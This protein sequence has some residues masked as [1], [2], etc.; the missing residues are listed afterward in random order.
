MPT[1]ND[2]QQS[3]ATKRQS[4]QTADAAYYASLQQWSLTGNGQAGV[5]ANQTARN[6]A[7]TDLQTAIG[8]LQSDSTSQQ[9]ITEVA[10]DLPFLLLPVRVEA[11]YVT[12]R[13]MLKNLNPDDI[14][15]IS[16][17]TEIGPTLENTGF[18]NDEDG[19]ITYLV[20]SVGV[21]AA[22]DP[23]LFGQLGTGALAPRSGKWIQRKDDNTELRIRIYPDDIYFESLEQNLQSS[24]WDAGVAFW[25]SIWSGSDPQTQWLQL[26]VTYRPAR[27]AWIIQTTRPTNFVSGQPL[28]ASPVFP[29]SQ[30]QKDG[31]Y[32]EPPRARLLPDCFVVRLYKDGS[33]SEFTGA[34]IPEPLVLGLDPTD[35]PFN[36]D[37]ASGMS[38]GGTSIQTPD[39]LN[40]IHDFDA[41]LANGLALRVDLTENPQYQNGVDKILV[42][43]VKLSADETETET[44]L[45][46]LMQNH[47]YKED[48]MSIVT[49]GTATNNFGDQKSGYNDIKTEGLAYFNAQWNS[50]P[51]SGVVDDGTR[52]QEALGLGSLF[53][54][55]MGVTTEI[56]EALMMNELLWP[57][58]WGY[59]LL[60]YYSPAMTEATRELARQFFIQHVAARGMLPVVRVNRQPYGIIPTTSLAQWQYSGDTLTDSENFLSG[61]WTGFLSKLYTLWQSWIPGI[62]TV[63]VGGQG[64]DSNFI[65]IVSMTATSQQLQRQWMAGLGFQSLL[66]VAQP[67]PAANIALLGDPFFQPAAFTSAL[68]STGIAIA[69]YSALLNAY[70]TSLHDVNR[71]IMDG[72]PV[73][74]DRPLELIAAKAWNYIEW[75]A[76]A[77]MMEIWS[78]DFSGAPA[79][80]G[81]VDSSADVS[82]FAVLARQA[83]LRAYLEAGIQTIETDAGLHLLK[84]KDFELEHLQ[85]AAM[86]VDPANMVPAN[87][88]LQEYQTVLAV[89]P[90]T[91]PFVLE[92]DRRQYFNQSYPATGSQNLSDWLDEQKMSDTLQPLKGAMQALDYFSQMSSAKLQRLLMEHLDLCSHRLDAWISG[93][94]Y[95]RIQKQR[96][97]KPAG[98]HIGAY[99]WLLGL[100]RAASPAIVFEVESPVYLDATVQNVNAAAIPL[101]HLV[102]AK[103]NGIDISAGSWNRAFFYLGSNADPGARLDTTTGEIEPV[104]SV[105]QNPSDGFIHAPSMSHAVA[106]AILRSAYI[107][108]DADN[109]TAL[110]SLQLNSPRVRQALQLLDGMQQGNSIG[111]LL[112]YYFERLLHDNQL[113]Q[114]L[115]DLRLAFPLPRTA[116]DSTSPSMFT[117]TDGQALLNAR[118]G[119]VPGWLTAVNGI[120]S[121]DYAKI[122]T[123]AAILEDY[124]DGLNDLLLAESVYQ[125]AKGNRDRAAAALRIMNG[126]GQVVTPEIVRTPMRGSTVT[127]RIGLVFQEPGTSPAGWTTTGTPRSGFMPDLNAWLVSRLPAPADIAIVV[128]PGS[129]T[130]VKIL[131]TD[132]NIEP[133]DLLYALPASFTQ[134]SQSPLAT[135]AQL[136]VNK[137]YQL[138]FPTTVQSFQIDFR[139]RTGLADSEISIFEIS[140]LLTA[141]R[142][143]ITAG[144]PISPN[145][146]LLPDEPAA[147]GTSVSTDRLKNTFQQYS[148]AAGPASR[149]IQMLRTQAD[150]LN[151]GLQQNKTAVELKAII[152]TLTETLL[153][154]WQLGVETNT[155]DGI[156]VVNDSN[157]AS[158]ANKANSAAAELE[159]RITKATAGFS[160]VPAGSDGQTFFS[161]IQNAS[162]ILYAGRIVL[163]PDINLAN[164]DEV[165]TAFNRRAEIKLQGVDDIGDWIR[166]AALV[167]K[168]LMA[169]RQSVFLSESLDDSQILANPVILQFP[170]YTGTDQ[171]WIGGRIPPDQP[172]GEKALLSLILEMPVTFKADVSFCGVIIDD[173]PEWIP[174]TQVDTGVSFQFNQPDTEP[175]QAML[176]AVTPVENANWTWEYLAGSI[177]EALTLAQ[178][179]LITLT[180]IRNNNSGLNQVLPAVRLPFLADNLQTPVVNPL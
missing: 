111:E 47:L 57:A 43:G 82:V 37:P 44:M 69:D 123:Q 95:Q 105:N 153:T 171:L 35:D 102:A 32:T 56:S 126:G 21:N 131:L 158:L 154:A 11:R 121:A 119:N 172:A 13:H 135:H 48:G 33:F 109:E 166:E 54:I 125:T 3:I 178:V 17:N 88:L 147:T 92:P 58:T 89:H 59:Y 4:Y 94:I 143:I 118:R 81:A 73:A 49:K 52:I 179:R 42:M 50:E 167:R 67:N 79:G 117:G 140:S 84:I 97:A 114:Y 34:S 40:W 31:P 87:L 29:A 76:Q 151:A 139:D 115:Y 72:L 122:D 38:Q 128:D 99:G 45:S 148:A 120:N 130:K 157:P 107:N 175:P 27:A 138:D 90:V 174:S 136:A 159:S 26:S 30:N 85:G 36:S 133:A 62:K 1:L 86:T 12:V 93:V 77:K 41:A 112:G 155:A 103:N 66:K 19:V 106:A 152:S 124:L 24:E 173:W 23:N 2:I 180:D 144:R 104:E 15:D 150:A 25:Q 53:R 132:L 145:D 63:A 163:L 100:A 129:G 96:S 161:A 7:F 39:Y 51:A 134:S 146:F 61:L 70:N 162:S 169:Y 65:D 168:N 16:N 177:N 98:I 71:V 149:T 116:T 6:Q 64:L 113:D 74:E 160:A 80:N 91:A 110:L 28:P 55:P 176:L 142:N 60:Q 8:M 156:C 10:G 127:H 46:E 78:A 75:L 137:K 68:N 164:P 20:P 165:N 18:I 108:H 83:V 9:R 101:A 14:L 141:L 170:F 22:T 5:V